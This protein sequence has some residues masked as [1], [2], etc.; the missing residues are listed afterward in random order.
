[1]KD[2]G[3]AIRSCGRFAHQAEQHPHPRDCES[4]QRDDAE[5]RDPGDGTRRGPEAHE[6][7]DPDDE[8]DADH[9]PDQA[10][11]NLSGQ[12]RGA[13]DRHGAE[14]GDDALAHI[15]TEIYRSRR[16]PAAYGHEDNRGRDVVDVGTAVRHAAKASAQ[17]PAEHVDE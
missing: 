14:A 3:E 8:D 9:R 12:H 2:E 6:Q 15:H 4:E 13:G 5:R 16:A 7:R 1:M 11:E 10:S 17:R